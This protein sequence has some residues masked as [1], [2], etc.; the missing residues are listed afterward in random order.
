[1]KI[2]LSALTL[3]LALVASPALAFQCPKDAAAI[4]AALAAGTSLSDAEVAEVKVL[5]DEGM[6]QHEAGDH[7]Q[8]VETLAK[9][10]AMLGLQ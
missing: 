5:R 1:M 9:A 8:S 4:D 10:L 3:A 6:A 7:G 2:T